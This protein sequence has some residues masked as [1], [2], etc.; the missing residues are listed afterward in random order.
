MNAEQSIPK[1]PIILLNAAVI[2][3]ALGYFVDIYDLLLFSIVRVPSLQSLGIKGDAVANKGVFILNVQMIGLLAGGIF[4]GILGDRK[5]RLSVLFGSILIYSVANIANGFAAS[6]NSYAT[7]RFIA[8]F[9]LAGELGS[10]IT[11]V[12]ELMPKEKRG[13]A[14]TIVASVGVFGAVV[15]FFIARHFPWRISYFIGG[16]LGL[17][18]LLLRVKVSESSV[19]SKS[20]KAQVSHGSFLLLFNN[21]SRFFKYL[22]CILI[23]VPLWFVVG[24]LITFSPEFGREMKV[25]GPVD[26]G[27]A[28]ACCYGGLVLGDIISGLLSQLLKSRVKVVYF[29]LF[30][31]AA[32]VAIFINLNRISLASFYVL[33][34][35]LG[36]SVGYWVIF[37]TIATEQFGTN[38]RATVTTTAP[39]FVRGMVVPITIAFEYLK[40]DIFHTGRGAAALVG[41]VCLALAF[42]SL[43]RMQE[44][45]SKD[46][47]YLETNNN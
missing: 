40:T 11:L 44:T 32:G 18:L 29:Y 4:W 27:A 10:G 16:S 14:T 23:G 21:W 15:A 6:I 7:W 35:G 26:A 22:R 1:R 19:F 43:S 2:V 12:A 24:I 20:R 38:I 47:N 42:W 30:L 41:A 17:C 46:L 5:G 31:A 3:A 13:Y 28:V 39:N 45:F 37:M 36:F 34:S 9:G 33:C 8:G 25:R